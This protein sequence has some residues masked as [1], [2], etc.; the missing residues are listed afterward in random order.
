MATHIL[1]NTVASISELKANPMKTVETG[2]GS[3]IAILNRNTPA[4][5]CVPAKV[6]EEM[7]DKL[8]DAELVA[9]IKERIDDKEEIVTV[10][11]EDL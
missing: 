3:T 1:A 4:F 5:Y 6:Y 8:E 11:W 2:E 10:E 7:M 9:L